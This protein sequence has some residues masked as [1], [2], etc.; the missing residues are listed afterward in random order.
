MRPY[1]RKAE[2]RARRDAKSNGMLN[3]EGLPLYIY[4][5]KEGEGA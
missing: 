2:A 1:A 5:S 4:T 3:Q